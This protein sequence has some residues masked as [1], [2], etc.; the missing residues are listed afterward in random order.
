MKNKEYISISKKFFERLLNNGCDVYEKNLK[1]IQNLKQIQ[2]FVELTE[3]ESLILE[4]ANELLMKK[5]ELIEDIIE[6]ENNTFYD[7]NN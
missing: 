5:L 4:N 3:E 1:I 2:N 6:D 7:I